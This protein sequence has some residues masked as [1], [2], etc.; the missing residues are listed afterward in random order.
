MV[1]VVGVDLT[2]AFIN[3]FLAQLIPEGA[4]F[5]VPRYALLHCNLELLFVCHRS[6]AP[7]MSY[8][9]CIHFMHFPAACSTLNLQLCVT[10]FLQQYITITMAH[11]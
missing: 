4:A 7:T 9:L 5:C 2:F 6:D 8:C 10:F 1:G 11:L 3:V